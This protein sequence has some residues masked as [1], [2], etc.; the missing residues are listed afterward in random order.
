MRLLGMNLDVIFGLIN[1]KCKVVILSIGICLN[2]EKVGKHCPGKPANVK[3]FQK[4]FYNTV[5][6]LLLSTCAQFKVFA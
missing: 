3:E 1:R 4:L 2:S 6:F 5:I